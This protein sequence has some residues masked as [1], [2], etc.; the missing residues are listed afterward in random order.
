MLVLTQRHDAIHCLEHFV[1]FEIL[2]HVDNIYCH[3]LPHFPLKDEVH[4][5]LPLMKSKVPFANKPA[6]AKVIF[7]IEKVLS[8]FY[9]LVFYYFTP[10]WI[11]AIPYLA[12]T[13]PSS[14]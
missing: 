12:K 9:S 14:H 1:A 2:T 7:V 5:S 13:S 3:A 8:S 10:F 6:T 4:H 11:G